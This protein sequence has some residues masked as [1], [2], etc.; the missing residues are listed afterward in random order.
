MSSVNEFPLVDAGLRKNRRQQSGQGL[1]PLLT[2]GELLRL[3]G[4]ELL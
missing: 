1:L 3:I 4:S 2:A